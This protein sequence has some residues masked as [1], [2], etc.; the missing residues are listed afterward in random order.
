MSDGERDPYQVLGLGPGA[1]SADI[2]R[3]WRRRARFVH[4]DSRPG[5]PAAAK[6]FQAVSDAY[7]L[8]SDPAR[9]AAWDRE[10]QDLP[11]R[12]H[13][14]QGQQA[15]AGPALWPLPP[16]TVAWP[17]SGRVHGAALRAGPVHIQPPA[18]TGSDGQAGPDGDAAL[19][20]LLAWL[21][22]RWPEWPW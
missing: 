5:D 7:G 19:A 8:L 18:P 15:P 2:T 11:A 1:T 3:A 10:H 4:P 14:S 16:A 21:A 13:V 20:R 17:T 9:R 22:P 12:H 6:Q